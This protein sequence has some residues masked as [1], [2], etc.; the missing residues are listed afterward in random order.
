M[1]PRVILRTKTISTTQNIPSFLPA[2]V[3]DI[4]RDLQT[5]A[6]SPNST[7]PDIKPPSTP[8]PLRLSTFSNYRLRGLRGVL[9]ALGD[10][11]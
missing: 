11:E 8:N 1:I 2:Y 5:P 6:T 4:A 9:V 3:E 10:G 7:S